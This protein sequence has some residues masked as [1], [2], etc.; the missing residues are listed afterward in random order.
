MRTGL[1]GYG[2]AAHPQETAAVTSAPT[3]VSFEKVAFLIV[4]SSF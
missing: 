1:F 2:S 3:N 4:S